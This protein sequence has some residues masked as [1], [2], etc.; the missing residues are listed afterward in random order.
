VKK[1]KLISSRN[2]E[3]LRHKRYEKDVTKDLLSHRHAANPNKLLNRQTI[4][5]LANVSY[6]RDSLQTWDSFSLNHNLFIFSNCCN[7]FYSVE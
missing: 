6:R 3:E 7:A 1:P 4:N 2:I 5:E